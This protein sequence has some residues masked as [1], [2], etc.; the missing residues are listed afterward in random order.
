MAVV[1]IIGTQGIPAQYGGFEML[2]QNL[3][4]HLS[5]QHSL[6]VYC[7][8]KAYD[9]RIPLYLGAKL[10]YIP[11]NA[12]GPQSIIYDLWSMLRAIPKADILLILGVSGCI[13]LPIIKLFSKKKIIV[14]LD[15][16]DWKRQKW[17]WFARGYL[18]ISERIAAKYA[19]CLIAD[20]AAIQDYISDTYNKESHLIAYGGDN[21]LIELPVNKDSDL[22]VIALNKTDNKSLAGIPDIRFNQY[23]F[24]VC[25]I[26]PENN[27]HMV[28]E[29]FVQT[30]ALPLIIVGDWTRNKYSRSLRTKYGHLENI[31]LLDPIWD[32]AQLFSLR[33][34]AK[35]YIHGHSA[36]GT[37]PS[38]VEAMCVGLPVFAFDVAF[39]RATTLDEAS[40]FS[41][42]EDLAAKLDELDDRELA[43][44]AERMKDIGEKKY[45]WQAISEQY[46]Q[47]FDAY[48]L[49][50]E[51]I[52]DK[53]IFSGVNY[54]ANQDDTKN[55][56]APTDLM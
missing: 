20:N 31:Q 12:N 5:K 19:D 27:I 30:K 18:K 52:R 47:L 37:N 7:S 32:P 39:N 26:E 21:A 53:D 6:I 9:E 4:K 14:N 55:L 28:L 44:L 50:N 54:T 36:G 3:A 10:E 38:L 51:H 8:S 45:T 25:R 11:L 15:G 41:S 2:A 13:F 46:S 22:S 56:R 23:A 43:R 24:S 1:A 29:A 17:K 42:K 48:A 33:I 16:I 35:L 49:Q 40:Y 34:N